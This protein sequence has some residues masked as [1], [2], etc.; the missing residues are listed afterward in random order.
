MGQ[1]SDW[2]TMDHSHDRA[3]LSLEVTLPGG[4]GHGSLSW[5][6]QNGEGSKAILTT[7]S[8][9]RQ[10]VGTWPAMRMSNGG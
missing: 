6:P 9:R 7:G 2:S 3:A 8:R 1:K 4:S 5:Q 10:A